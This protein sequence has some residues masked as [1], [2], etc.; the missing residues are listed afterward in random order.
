LAQV[1]AVSSGGRRSISQDQVNINL[2]AFLN[3]RA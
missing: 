2:L 3:A 1:A